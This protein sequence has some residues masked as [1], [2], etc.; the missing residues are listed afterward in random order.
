MD[1]LR[2]VAINLTAALIFS[3]LGFLAGVSRGLVRHYRNRVANSFWRRLGDGGVRVVIAPHRRRSH[4]AWEPSG[5]YGAGDVEALAE[6][7]RIRAVLHLPLARPVYGAD[8]GRNDIH[9]NLILIGGPD[10]NQ[11]T[12]D[13]LDGLGRMRRV[14]LAFQGGGRTAVRLHDTRNRRTYIAKR[15]PGHFFRRGEVVVDYGIIVFAEN[16]F[17]PRRRMLIVAGGYGYAT[18]AGLRILDDKRFLAHPVVRSGKPF[19]CLHEVNVVSGEVVKPEVEQ[20]DVRSLPLLH[21]SSGPA[22]SNR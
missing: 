21:G 6:L 16:P 7:Q 22:A 17:N 5:L 4:V 18:L 11:V 10:V 1:D 15:T 20:W 3:L 12:R 2:D 14:G 13:A 19:E 8:I 9:G